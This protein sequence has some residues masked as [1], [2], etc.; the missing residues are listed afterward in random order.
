M[1]K[2]YM[3]SMSE[4][5]VLVTTDKSTKSNLGITSA[6]VLH[7]IC[8]HT[9]YDLHTWESKFRLRTKSTFFRDEG[10]ISPSTMN[11]IFRYSVFL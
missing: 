11:K 4:P 8:E 1:S 3:T 6:G 10:R 5:R 9:C 2:S 7:V